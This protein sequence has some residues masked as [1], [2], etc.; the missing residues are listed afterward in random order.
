[1]TSTIPFING[2]NYGN[3]FI[4]ESFFAE[5]FYKMNE[6]QKVADQHSLCDLTGPGAQQSMT[7]YLDSMIKE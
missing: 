5:E 3:I 6:V 4:P 7:N 2:V 1:M